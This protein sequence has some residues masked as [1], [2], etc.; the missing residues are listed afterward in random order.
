[1]WINSIFCRYFQ[2]NLKPRATFLS[3]ARQPE[4]DFLHTWAMILQQ[5]G[6]ASW[7]RSAQIKQQAWPMAER[8]IG[9]R[10]SSLVL[11]ARF[12]VVKWRSRS[13]AK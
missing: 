8:Q 6:N 11:Y 5:N 2:E 12:P 1:M 7:R 3:G 13:V 9:H 10:K 4:V